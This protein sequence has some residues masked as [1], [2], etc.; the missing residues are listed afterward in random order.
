MIIP[1]INLLVY[2]YNDQ[3]PLHC[4]ARV[5][6][7]ECMNGKTPI[8][9]PWVV[10]SGFLRL[11]THPK[12]LQQPLP[13]RTAADHVRAWLDQPP[14]RILQPGAR[15][16]ELFFAFLEELGSGGNLTTDAQI[17]ALTVE[18]QAVLH[19]NDADYFRFSGLRWTNPLNP[20]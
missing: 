11:T 18:N 10:A 19:S 20:S 5:W 1:D 6:W 8:G 2:A 12:I 4:E 15:F 17:A 14:V 7:E 16:A 13:V 3:A 9:L